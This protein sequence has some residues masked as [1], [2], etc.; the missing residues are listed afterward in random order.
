M[1]QILSI[2]ALSFLLS[3]SFVV[4]LDTKQVGGDYTGLTPCELSVSN[5]VGLNFFN[6]I[7]IS[8]EVCED[9]LPSNDLL[10]QKWMWYRTHKY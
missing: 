9:D 4:A 7:R 1:K 8:T 2:L 3:V 6:P 10:A 5:G